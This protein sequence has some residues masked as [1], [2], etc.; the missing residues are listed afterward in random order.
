MNELEYFL[1][2]LLEPLLQHFICL[3]KA[4][5]LQVGKPNGASLKQ[6]DQPPWRRHNDVATIPNLTHLLLNIA[7]SIHCH[8]FEIPSNPQG[9][10][11]GAHLDRQL[12]RLIVTSLV[13]TT[14]KN[15]SFPPSLKASSFLKRSMIGREKAIVLP[16]PVLSLAM[17]SFPLKI[18]S[19]V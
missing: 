4:S 8:H 6:V 9:P 3:V 15:F 19:K 11:F 17:R 16:E 7:P 13:G 10:D 18:F 12:I 5:Y 14:I 1:D 2:V